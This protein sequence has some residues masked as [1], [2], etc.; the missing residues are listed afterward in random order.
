MQ[1]QLGLWDAAPTATGWRVRES[2]RARRLS[3][4]VYRDGQVEIVVPRGTRPGTVAG[5]VSRYRGW[6]ERQQRRLPPPE[7]P[8][9]PPAQVTLHAVG[10]H[11]DCRFEPVAGP[12][13]VAVARPPGPG[14]IG[15]LHLCAAV[16][17]MAELRSALLRWLEERTRAA[18]T[19]LLMQLSQD[20][21]CHYSRLQIRRQRTRWGSCSTRGTISLNCCLLFQR[22]E[23]FRYLLVHE[24]SHLRHM[25]HGP[26]F[27]SHVAHFESDCRALDRELGQGWRRVPHWALKGSE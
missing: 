1:R 8:T 13:R 10:E 5:F 17:G 20:M 12:A 27:W 18:A 19:P 6:I 11:W 22:P 3:A 16:D 26:R 23:V 21:D 14:A 4:R 15:E 9:F 2:G 25:H 7:L 24:L